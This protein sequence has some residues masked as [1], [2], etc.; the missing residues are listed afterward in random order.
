M[1]QIINTPAENRVLLDANNT[2]ISIQSTN[3]AG[4]YFRALIYVDDLLFDEQGWSREDAYTAKKDLVKLYN[5]YFKSIFA[6][7]F[8]NAITEQTHLKKKINIT[9]EE[10]NLLT[11]AVVETLQLPTFYMLYNTKPV[12]F[13]DTLKIQ[14]LG[15]NATVLQVPVNGKIVLPFAVNA[16]AEN[17]VVTVKDNF[18]TT[19]N[20]KTL[21]NITGKKIY[22]YAFDLSTVTLALNTI[23]FEV[24]LKCGLTEIVKNYR[25]MR[26]PDY[27]VKEI[28]FQNNF[29][30]FIPAYFDGELEV[31]NGLKIEDYKQSDGTSKVFEINEEAVYTI[32]T[33]TLL[34]DERTII[35][36]I[37]N[38]LEVRFKIDAEWLSIQTKTK[39]E[40]IYRDKKHLYGEDLQFTF[41]KQG[42]NNNG[43]VT[44]PILAPFT[45]SGVGNAE[46][47]IAKSIIE[48]AYTN[49]MPLSKFRVK[50]LPAKGTLKVELSSG[51]SDV[52]V[53][54][55]YNWSDII[56]FK[57][58]SGVNTYGSPYTTFTC[59]VSNGYS[60][61]ASATATFNITQ[62]TLINQPPVITVNN[63]F[64]IYRDGGGNVSYVVPA[65]I[66]DPN[67]DAVTI[68]W[69]I[70]GS[71][72]GLTLTN[73][74][75]ATPTIAATSAS[76][77][78]ITLKCT[79][80]DSNAAVTIK[81]ITINALLGNQNLPPVISAPAS[82][83]FIVDYNNPYGTSALSASVTDPNGDAFTVKWLIEG[84][85]EN[86]SLINSTSINAGLRVIS[87]PDPNPET[88]YAAIQNVRITA[89]DIFGN[90]SYVIIPI[91]VIYQTDGL[92]AAV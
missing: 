54:T 21:T 38:S 55:I 25:L 69:E 6:A 39:K 78:T 79:A 12:L 44:M 24:S 72:T 46:F 76:S 9:I 23:Y 18:G 2:E 84:T 66:T 29:G 85:S 16:T 35:N 59:E 51:T 87:F 37:I 58:I 65:V 22:T 40:L 53:N 67:G 60:F 4:F 57:Y 49:E 30:Y 91:N 11:D 41:V 89:T 19:L 8:P 33:G 62:G 20:T 73:Q 5:A 15:I 13:N 74:T 80:T 34:L 88:V 90:A 92:L 61:S 14:L 27:A 42:I 47:T 75:T 31:V 17:V 28:I 45:I 77:N 3:G 71:T 82:F 36:D 50:T 70:V 43:F 7:S 48:A 32:N 52:T 86:V 26:F 63:S 83:D 68:L 64:T 10:R 81:T 56:Q 1:I